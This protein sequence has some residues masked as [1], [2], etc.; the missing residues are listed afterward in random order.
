MRIMS[1]QSGVLGSV[2]RSRDKDG[3]IEQLKNYLFLYATISRELKVVS[4]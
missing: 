2:R 3:D 1:F 4:R